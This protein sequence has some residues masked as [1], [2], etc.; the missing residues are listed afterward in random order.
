MLAIIISLLSGLVL[1]LAVVAYV[2]F[3]HR[4]A[5]LPMAPHFGDAMRRGV[6]SLPTLGDDYSRQ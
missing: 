2:A 6:D 3:P 1:A 5:Q 4:G